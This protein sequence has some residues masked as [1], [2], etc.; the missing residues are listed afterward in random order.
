M[1]ADSCCIDQTVAEH[2]LMHIGKSDCRNLIHRNLSGPL[3]GFFLFLTFLLLTADLLAIKVAGVSWRM[4]NVVSW[5]LMLLVIFSPAFKLNIKDVIVTLIFCGVIVFLLYFSQNSPRSLFF[6]FY[7]IYLSILFLI[8]IPSIDYMVVM[9]EFHRSHVIISLALISIYCAVQVGIPLNI[10]VDSNRGFDRVHFWSYEP[11]YIATY[12]STYLFFL[13]LSENNLKNKL[14]VFRVVITTIALGTTFSL[15]A[16]LGIVASFALL[17]G[18]SALRIRRGGIAALLAVSMLATPMLWLGFK[19]VKERIETTS[20]LIDF[21]GGRVMQYE[22]LWNM[23]LK[24]PWTGVGLGAVDNTEELWLSNVTLEIL[25]TGGLM[26]MLALG[27]VTLYAIWKGRHVRVAA[28]LVGALIFH[29]LLLQLNQNYMRLYTWLY[30]GVL[31]SISAGCQK[32]YFMRQ[33]T[34]YAK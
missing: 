6:T 20:N 26:L 2:S 17:I 14:F 28:A 18:K 9:R 34:N 4:A 24:H 32:N 1:P 33:E 25:A 16:T 23:F 27:F 7:I 10:M 8:V 30:L 21:G 22:A 19:Y 12:L 15:T 31:L 29:L 13:A 5:I 3:I 11:S